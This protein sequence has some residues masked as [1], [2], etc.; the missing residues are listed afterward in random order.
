[1]LH[2]ATKKKADK[3]G[4]ELAE[5]PEGSDFPY[6]AYAK[7][8][9][10]A[11]E[12]GPKVWCTEIE[13]FGTDASEL[14]AAATFAKL[15]ASNHPGLWFEQEEDGSVKMGFGSREIG[16]VEDLG[17]LDEATMEA[18][19]DLNDDERAELVAAE[20]EAE[21]DERGGS[22]VP[23]KYKKKYA[24]EGHAGNCGDWLA[25]TLIDVTTGK[26]GKLDPDAVDEIARLNEIDTSKY[27]RTT[28]G[29]QGRLRMTV[30]NS[31]VK[32]VAAK[33]FLSVPAGEH[34]DHFDAPPAWVAANA[35]K[36]KETKGKK[37]ATTGTVA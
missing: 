2:H 37:Q 7:V 27:N 23:D 33:G 9:D 30:R 25:L 28:P 5:A 18:L 16:K 22:V 26:D 11:K 8:R 3:A 31:L 4:V 1:M 35:P 36:P 14:L 29:W 24:E 32:K 15:M 21:E 19:D 34:G 17:D 6:R 10:D 20:A 13:F 12:G